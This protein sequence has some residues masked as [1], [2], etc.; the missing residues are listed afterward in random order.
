MGGNLALWADVSRDLEAASRQVRIAAVGRATIKT[1]GSRPANSEI[2]IVLELGVAK[3]IEA[4][5][6]ALEQALERLVEHMMAISP[7]A[8]AITGRSSIASA[9]R[10]RAYV[11][12]SFQRT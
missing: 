9:I 10:W 11:Q 2:R 12:P 5:S 8:K 1:T 6:T 3:A 4:T 7:P